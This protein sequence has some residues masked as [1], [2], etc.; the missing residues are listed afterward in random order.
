[1]RAQDLEIPYLNTFE[2]FDLLK[3]NLA[4]YVI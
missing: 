4:E 1:M 2:Q 3:R